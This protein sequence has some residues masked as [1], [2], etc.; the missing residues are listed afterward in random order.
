MSQAPGIV[1]DAIGALLRPLLGTLERVVWVQRHLHPSLAER[2]ADA[3]APGLDAMAGPL[4]ALQ[5]H[6][7][8]DELDFARDRLVDVARQT[9]DMVTAFVDAARAGGEPF[10]LYRALRRFGRVQEAL[11]P[12]APAF[13]GVSRWFLEPARRDDDAL[14]EAL[15]AGAVREDGVRAGVL[16]ADNERDA[17]GGFSLYVPE[18]WDGHASM[19]L[20]VALHGGHGHGRDFLWT[21]LREAR[22][23]GMLVLSPT[24]QARTWSIM[25]ADVDGPALRQMVERVA[26]RHPVDRARVLLTGMS[27]GATYGMR[28]FLAEGGPFT[29][30]A[31]A[32]GMLLPFLL[33]GGAARL[34]DRPVY[35]VHGRLD[36]MFPVDTARAARDALLAAGARL[37]YRELDDLSHTYPRDENPAILDWL[38]R[39]C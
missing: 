5:S 21:W 12:L 36:W 39:M 35:L 38:A 25:G 33:G 2:L 13:G 14:V 28:S 23:R 26:E 15:R 32:C 30:L 37:V 3:L 27:D 1:L 31:P 9:L 16:H 8:P 29:H 11:Y 24:A 19:P 6:P 18:S 4:D 34:R 10:D 17:R 22:A 20:I 7:R